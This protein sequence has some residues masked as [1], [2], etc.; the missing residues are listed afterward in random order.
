MQQE[1]NQD[2]IELIDEL[3]DLKAAYDE[4]DVQTSAVSV[5]QDEDAGEAMLKS[6]T[7][8]NVSPEAFKRLQTAVENL[9][10]NFVQ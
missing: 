2:I 6:E 1:E 4:I 5:D 8:I 3:Q 7:I 10:T 9:R